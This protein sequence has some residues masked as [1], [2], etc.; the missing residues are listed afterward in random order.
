MN[1]RQL[2]L[3]MDNDLINEIREILRSYQNPG[4][5]QA[6]IVHRLSELRQQP[7]QYISSLGF[8]F[9]NFPEDRNS[10]IIEIHNFARGWNSF[11]GETQEG[12]IQV[13]ISIYPIFFTNA[14]TGADIQYSNFLDT[15][16]EICDSYNSVPETF[17]PILNPQQLLI[18][19]F[20][21]ILLLI[22]QVFLVLLFKD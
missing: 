9:Q 15:V 21:S 6:A 22:N 16:M 17:A 4:A 18:I 8:I 14:T 11:P 10:A 12:I 3:E 1:D 7:D 2:S 5:N 20:L 19:N 13:L